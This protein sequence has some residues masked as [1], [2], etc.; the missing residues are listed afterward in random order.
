M[1]ERQDRDAFF[2]RGWIRFPADPSIAAWAAA[3]RPATE[4]LMAAPDAEY[5]CDGTWF[6]GVNILPNAG[7]GRLE[8]GPALAGAP[9][10][11]VS[12]ALAL[13]GFVW[14]RAQVSACLPGYP[15]QGEEETDAAFRFRLNRDA[16][17]VDGLL[18]EKPARNRWLG[19]THGFILGIPLV[20]AAPSAS[21]MTVWEGSHE[22]MRAAFRRAFDGVD[23]ARWSEIDLTEIYQETRR[24]C[25]ETCPRVEIPARFGESYLVHRLA[26]H[27]VSPWRAPPDDP[28]RIIA[29]LRPDPFPGATPEW[30][31]ARA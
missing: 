31:L 29:Y 30:W 19:E 21:P 28:P 14:D 26:L 3:A 1:S 17:H 10:D 11:F 7:D 23:P 8:N 24:S 5:R 2:A 16:A 13:D 4:A 22:I 27:G 12:E 6:P 15:R 9:L 18:R 25:F 20:D